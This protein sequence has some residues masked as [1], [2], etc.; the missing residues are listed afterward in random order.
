MDNSSSLLL[1]FVGLFTDGMSVREGAKGAARSSFAHPTGVHLWVCGPSFWRATGRE[2]TSAVCQ[3]ANFW[4]VEHQ[5]HPVAWSGGDDL[6]A[7]RSLSRA[8]MRFFVL[9]VAC[10]TR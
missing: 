9:A 5:V 1:S 8:R 7:L 10:V 2:F 3:G 4:S 6:L